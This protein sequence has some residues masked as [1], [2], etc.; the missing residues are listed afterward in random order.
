M[1]DRVGGGVEGEEREWLT[2]LQKKMETVSANIKDI[3]TA[4]SQFN[5]P[6]V[7]SYLNLLG[8][9]T[10]Q[11]IYGKPSLS[12]TDLRKLKQSVPGTYSRKE[13]N[14]PLSSSTNLR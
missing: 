8:K 9:H 6:T 7:N 14:R 5:G 2:G 1:F 10:V 13:I 3:E 12:S 11:W 4:A